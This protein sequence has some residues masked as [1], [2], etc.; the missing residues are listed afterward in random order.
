MG[1]FWAYVEFFRSFCYNF[2]I[3]KDAFGMV[4]R[5]KAPNMG[6]N[7]VPISDLRRQAS[8]VINTLREGS[9]VAYITQHGRPAAV[10]V[11]FEQYEALLA[12]IEELKEA[13]ARSLYP[14]IEEKSTFAIL[15]DMAE[16]LGVDDL[17]EEHD[18]YLY[19]VD[20]S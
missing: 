2:G 12:Q 18:H 19:G 9:D 8:K 7:I 6:V 16:D 3:I 1:A 20:K 11:N 5:E 15:A 4:N 10:L 17:A 14:I 13:Q